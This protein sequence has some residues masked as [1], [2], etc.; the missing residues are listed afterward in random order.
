MLLAR[1]PFVGSIGRVGAMA[2]LLGAVCAMPAFIQSLGFDLSSSIVA[3]PS[4][5]RV[6]S[7]ELQVALS[8]TILVTH[9]QSMLGWI[10]SFAGIGFCALASA[11]YRVG[12]DP[13]F[14]ILGAGFLAA[15]LMQASP[16]FVWLADGGSSWASADMHASATWIYVRMS[17][18]LLLVVSASFSVW[19]AA[20]RHVSI[21]S[22]GIL[23]VGVV[24]LGAMVSISFDPSRIGYQEAGPNAAASDFLPMIVATA[25]LHLGLALLFCKIFIRRRPDALSACLLLAVIPLLASDGYL[26]GSTQAMDSFFNSAR[27]LTSIAFLLPLCGLLLEVVSTFRQYG[28]QAR[29]LSKQSAMFKAQAQDLDQARRRAEEASRAKG[30]F[31]ANMSHEIRTPLTAIV[32]YAELL[33]RPQKDL[34]ERE[35]WAR[36]L[37]RGSNHLLAMV[38]DILDLSKIEAGKMGVSKRSQSPVLVVRQ[39]VQLMLPQ[40]KEKDAR[41]FI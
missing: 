40:A 31:L 11:R 26:I 19:P 23:L 33:A 9:L 1:S 38:N 37:R 25:G 15:G 39:V 4:N 14:P 29:R 28:D 16:N 5:A 17:T 18:A 27:I 6:D 8:K 32:G 41:A 36:G 3:W 22:M 34:S 12:R 24:S 30:E 21:G 10:T 2:L 20:H 7:G 35:A 13:L